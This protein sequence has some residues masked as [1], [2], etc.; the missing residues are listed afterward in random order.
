[1]G[2]I[3]VK[4][5]QLSTDQYD[6]IGQPIETETY[7]EPLAD[8][9]PITQSEFLAAGQRGFEAQ[10]KYTVWESEFHGEEILEKNG[11]RYH[12]YRTYPVNGRRELYVGWRIG[13]NQS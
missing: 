5:I 2:M 11:E 10:G 3:R 7:T 8:E 6:S 9:G 1:M 12:I 13:E 4:L